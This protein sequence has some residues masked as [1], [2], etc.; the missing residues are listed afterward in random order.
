[1]STQAESKYLWSNGAKTSS[2]SVGTEGKY[3][4][5]VNNKYCKYFDSATLTFIKTGL[6]LGPDTFY[7]GPIKF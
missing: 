2:I 5:L 6:E 1:M 7:C 4:V 3:S